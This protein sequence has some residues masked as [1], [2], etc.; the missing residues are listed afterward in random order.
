MSAVGAMPTTAGGKRFRFAGLRGVARPDAD[1]ETQTLPA[2]PCK[3][4]KR[5][6]AALPR[7]GRALAPYEQ[8]L[9]APQ[10]SHFRQVPLRA[11]VKLPHSEHGSPS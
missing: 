2:V 9:V 11:R 7:E 4:G 6:L 10:V 8:P 5:R 3:T 1:C